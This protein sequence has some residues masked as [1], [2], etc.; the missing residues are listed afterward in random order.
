MKNRNS[1]AKLLQS[2]GHVHRSHRSSSFCGVKFHIS[3]QLWLPMKKAFKKRK[4]FVLN[5]YLPFFPGESSQ[6]PAFACKDETA[7]TEKVWSTE[8][9]LASCVYKITCGSIHCGW[10]CTVLVVFTS[11]YPI[12][13]GTVS[14]GFVSSRVR[15]IGDSSSSITRVPQ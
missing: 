13:A 10:K 5:K 14:S 9:L 6:P 15:P 11:F 3:G 7:R 1:H 8:Y 2:L 12:M 4:E